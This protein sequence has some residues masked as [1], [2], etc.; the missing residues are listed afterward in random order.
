MTG[1]VAS[2]KNFFTELIKLG[3]PPPWNGNGYILP[4]NKYQKLLEKSRNNDNKFYK[5]QGLV[6]GQDVLEMLARD[7][8]IFHSL[9][10]IFKNLHVVNGTT[11]PPFYL[12]YWYFPKWILLIFEPKRKSHKPLSH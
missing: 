10:G 8:E 5:L 9:E 2:F 7:F 3:F 12:L 4:K 6:L 11:T 1:E